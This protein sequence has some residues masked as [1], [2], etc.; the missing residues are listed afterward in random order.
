MKTSN[1]IMFNDRLDPR[2]DLIDHARRDH[3]TFAV[4][5][6]D[7]VDSWTVAWAARV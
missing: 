7:V 3:V 2:H 4:V 6:E 1:A 5:E